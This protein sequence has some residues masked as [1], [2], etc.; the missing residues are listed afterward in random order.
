MI[1]YFGY[2]SNLDSTS[3]RA[4]GVIPSRSRPAVL[5]G[6]R[7]RFN[8]EH[9][10]PHEGGMGNIEET[11]DPADQVHG[12]LHT[13]S[14]ADLSAL[15]RVEAYG[16]GY[17]RIEVQLDT[18][19]GGDTGL[20]YVGLP[21]FIN[22]DCHPTQRYLNILVRGAEAADLPQDYVDALKNMIILQQQDLPLFVPDPT[23]HRIFTQDDLVNDPLLTAIW[24]AVFDMR[25][26][27]ARHEILKTWFGGQDVT[28]FHLKRL[29]SS[30]GTET[31]D[32]IRS[33]RLTP[34]QQHYLNT[35]LHAFAREY[36]YIGQFDYSSH[37]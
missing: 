18:P 12:V 21:D 5:T 33:G 19:D 31:L 11:G 3:L 34:G 14:D 17:D 30:D 20:A 2:G 15:D 28:L 9:F 23:R 13:C 27:R 25:Q 26:A 6:W 22:H 32:D 4:K 8:V 35:Y 36:R 24:G 7:L 10:F 29:D 1:N 37:K 16:I